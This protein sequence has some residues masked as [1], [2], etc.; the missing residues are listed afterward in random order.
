M[1]SNLFTNVKLYGLRVVQGVFLLLY[2]ICSYMHLFTLIPKALL[3][4]IG[5]EMP[6]VKYIIKTHGSES[7]GQGK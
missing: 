7:R 3:L 6:I 5:I 4:C 2:N 1:Y